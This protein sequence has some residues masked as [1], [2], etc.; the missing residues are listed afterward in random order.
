MTAM[1]SAMR[2]PGVITP[3]AW[4]WMNEGIVD[5]HADGWSVPSLMTYAAYCPRGPSMP[6]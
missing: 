3:T 1:V 2:W 6:A 4:R 5:A